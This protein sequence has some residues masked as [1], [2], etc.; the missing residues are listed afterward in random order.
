M[1][2]IYEAPRDPSRRRCRPTHDRGF[3]CVWFIDC[4]VLPSWVVGSNCK[5]ALFGG[6]AI[7]DCAFLFCFGHVLRFQAIE[8]TRRGG[9][10]GEQRRPPICVRTRSCNDA[11]HKFRQSLDDNG[12]RNEH[13]R[14]HLH[15]RVVKDG[16]SG[17]TEPWLS[18]VSSRGVAT[19]IAESE[20]RV[21]LQNLLKICE[22]SGLSA[23]SSLQHS[24]M[25]SH[26]TSIIPISSAFSGLRGRSPEITASM[27]SV[28][29][30]G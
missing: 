22:M 27:I 5:A 11:S 21:I 9:C 6:V 25:S 19:S 26:T 3:P 16:F 12:V 20:V 23:L 29:L 14:L 8:R 2:P 1:I 30:F 18:I 28:S 24:P 7:F 10:G 13:K 17:T 4:E 15:E